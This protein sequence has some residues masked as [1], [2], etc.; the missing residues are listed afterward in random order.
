MHEGHNRHQ[1]ADVKAV[2]SWII[3]VVDNQ[4]FFGQ[5]STNGFF[6]GVMGSP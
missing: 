6:I 5:L 1:M 2:S 4:L 3:T